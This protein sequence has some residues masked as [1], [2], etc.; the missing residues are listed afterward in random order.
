[1]IKREFSVAAFVLYTLRAEEE[2]D[3]HEVRVS[4]PVPLFV[5]SLRR[6]AF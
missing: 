2:R 1:M 4:C 6:E 3:I 5:V